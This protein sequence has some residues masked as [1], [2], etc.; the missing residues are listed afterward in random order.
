[1]KFFAVWIDLTKSTFVAIYEIEYSQILEL[2][3]ILN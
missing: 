1:M 3:K 2:S